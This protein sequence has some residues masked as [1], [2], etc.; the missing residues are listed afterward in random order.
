MWFPYGNRCS[1]AVPNLGW[2]VTPSAGAKRRRFRL[3]RFAPPRGDFIE[4]PRRLAGPRLG[5]ERIQRVRQERGLFAVT[6][7]TG[8]SR[9]LNK[10]LNHIG[11]SRFSGVD[12]WLL[13]F[14]F[15]LILFRPGA[16]VA[17]FLLHHAQ[18]APLHRASPGAAWF[19]LF[20][21]VAWTAIGVYLGYCIYALKP[22]SIR[23]TKKYLCAEVIFSLIGARVGPWA[24]RTIV[25]DAI[26]LLYLYN[27]QQVKVL[28]A[29]T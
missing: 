8:K 22:Q 4:S 29:E 28:F 25:F 21:S 9:G 6:A 17:G 24:L 2:R 5:C 7:S 12:G 15:T 13:F 19:G 18:W 3:P 16:V 14:C 27:S 26:W 10:M 20:S 23:W 1:R 11:E